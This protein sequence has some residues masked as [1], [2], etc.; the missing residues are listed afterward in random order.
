MDCAESERRSGNTKSTHSLSMDTIARPAHA[1]MNTRMKSN[2]LSN[3]PVPLSV[4]V[5]L[6]GIGLVRE[7]ATGELA[8]RFLTSS[9]IK[10]ATYKTRYKTRSPSF[11]ERVLP[12]VR[13]PRRFLVGTPRRVVRPLPL[14]VLPCR[15]ETRG[16]EGGGGGIG[17]LPCY[18][19]RLKRTGAR[20]MKSPWM[21]FLVFGGVVLGSVT[22][23]AYLIL[24]LRTFSIGK[25]QVVPFSRLHAICNRT[26]LLGSSAPP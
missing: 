8:M 19:L 6:A 20:G 2:S 3:N 4:G 9:L 25:G 11:I 13:V 26:R 10:P 21:L 22:A 18:R 15:R 14:P 5:G 7:T 23:P 1:T 16:R 17:V 12:V 24:S